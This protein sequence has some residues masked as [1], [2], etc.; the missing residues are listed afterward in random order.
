MRH[1]V[2]Y[3]SVCLISL[4]EEP[5]LPTFGYRHVFSLLGFLGFLVVYFLRVCVSVAVVSMAE[6]FHWT[7]GQ[8]GAVLSSFFVGYI[9]LQIPGGSTAERI[10]GKWIFGG[11]VA[12]ACVFTLLTPMAAEVSFRCLIA[13]RALT[14][15]CEGVTF[16]CMHAM[17]SRW[18]PPA[19]RTSLGAFTYC[20]AGM[21]SVLAMPVTGNLEEEHVNDVKVTCFAILKL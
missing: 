2:K 16:P 19:E 20:G 11:G 15:L 18:A 14:G 17:L 13:V 4:D 6:E 8:R 5:R 7:D 1:V 12:A 10:G 3:L 9:L 21:G